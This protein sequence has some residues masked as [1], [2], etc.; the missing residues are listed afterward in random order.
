M[1]RSA[2]GAP[3]SRRT[4]PKRRAWS[5]TCASRSAANGL[6]A[7]A[8]SGRRAPASGSLPSRPG[9]LSN[10]LKLVAAET[11]RTASSAPRTSRR[12]SGVV[13]VVPPRT[14][15]RTIAVKRMPSASG[16]FVVADRL[17]RVAEVARVDVARR[18]APERDGIR[19]LGRGGVPQPAREPRGEGHPSRAVRAHAEDDDLV[20]EAREHLTGVRRAPRPERR[21]GDRATEV[22]LAAVVLDLSRTSKSRSRSPSGW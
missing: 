5:A 22:E 20:G 7:A 18:A 19:A 17:L 3:R 2:G 11:R 10:P 8:A 4:R 9:D 16:S 6:A 14:T 15:A 1:G 13:R 21:G 12:P